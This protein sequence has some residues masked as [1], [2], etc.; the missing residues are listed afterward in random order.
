MFRRLYEQLSGLSHKLDLIE[1]VLMVREPGSVK[2]AEAYEGL[3]RQVVAAVDQ[4]QTH[5]AHLA[6]FDVALQRGE[7]AEDLSRLVGDFFQQAGLLRVDDPMHTDAYEVV[8]GKGDHLVVLAPAYV[9]A[10]TGRLVR[11]GRARA[12][13]H[14][15]AN[16]SLVEVDQTTVDQ[17]S[18]AVNR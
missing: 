15:T 16:G 4:R 11:Q 12:E 6:Q 8:G 9:D 10:S 18:E 1:R 13:A 7:S 3:R 14:P 17:T 5:L 2:A